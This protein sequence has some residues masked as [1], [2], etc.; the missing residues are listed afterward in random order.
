MPRHTLTLTDEQKTELC[1]MRDNG[2]PAYLRERAAAILK[3][4][5]GMSPHKVALSGLLKKRKPDTVYNWLSRFREHGIQGLF[6]KPGRGR[7]P[8]FAPKSKEDAEEELQNTVGMSPDTISEH[9]TRWT[10][11]QIK[12][13]VPWLTDISEAGVIRYFAYSNGF[14][15]NEACY[16]VSGQPLHPDALASRFS[17]VT[18]FSEVMDDVPLNYW[19]RTTNKGS[20]GRIIEHSRRIPR[21]K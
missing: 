4:G 16:L 15:E 11:Q 14:R 18:R 5:S 13:A 2:Q 6:Q 1:K 12:V 10:L 17:K 3:I 21:N 20:D 7:K 8:A 9:T 19:C